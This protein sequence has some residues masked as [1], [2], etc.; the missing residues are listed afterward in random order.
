MKKTKLKSFAE[1]VFCKL[2]YKVK[3]YGLEKIDTT[4]PCVYVAN[5]VSAM[6]GIFIWTQINNLAVMAKAEL[7]KNRLVAKV[8]KANGVFPIERG[9]KDFKHVYHAVKVIKAGN[10][11]LIFPEGT[12][13]ARQR[14]INPK[15]GATYIALATNVDI[16]PLHITEKIKLF[17]K[18]NIIAGDAIKLDLS[19]EKIKNKDELYKN[20]KNIMDIVYSLGDKY[21]R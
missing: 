1:F 3:F 10:S 15:N 14:G 12:R 17:G 20:T 4:K 13:N 11:L 9:K 2:L 18:V 16:I 6:D 8:L 7:F 5:H 19:K 21:D